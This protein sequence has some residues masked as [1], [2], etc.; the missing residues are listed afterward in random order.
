[1]CLGHSV[2]SQFDDYC[3]ARQHVCPE[4]TD[5]TLKRY[6]VVVSVALLESK[7]PGEALNNGS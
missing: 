5:E 2:T 6:A 7:D 3:F 1:M 4:T